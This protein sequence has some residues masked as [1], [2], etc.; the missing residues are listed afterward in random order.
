MLLVDGQ[1]HRAAGGELLRECE[2]NWCV[3]RVW[4]LVPTYLPIYL[5]WLDL[6]G[7]TLGGAGT[8]AA[9]ITKGYKLPAYVVFR[10][11]LLFLPLFLVTETDSLFCFVFAV[12]TLSM[13]SVRSTTQMRPNSRQNNSNPVTTPL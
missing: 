6:L 7:R 2:W 3:F 10:P 8:G 12:R 1:I 11:L 4:I 13:L 9:K 5:A